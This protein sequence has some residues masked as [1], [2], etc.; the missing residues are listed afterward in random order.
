MVLTQAAIDSLQPIADMR[1]AFGRDAF[2]MLGACLRHP[3]TRAIQDGVLKFDPPDW[4]AG[5][6][7]LGHLA[8]LLSDALMRFINDRRLPCE[9]VPS[10]DRA[11]PA[12]D[13][14]FGIDRAHHFLHAAPLER[15]QDPGLRE[16]QVTKGFA[17]FL[18]DGGCETR[19]GR[20]RALLRGA[21]FQAG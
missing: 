11:R 5:H 19:T 20:L 16:L 9:P 21:R 12:L 7:A 1:P 6:K 15:L 18:N 17:H 2:C 14:V 4:T 10:W 8:R 13:S 3:V